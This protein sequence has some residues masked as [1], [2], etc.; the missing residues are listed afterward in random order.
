MLAFVRIASSLCI[1]Y[2]MKHEHYSAQHA[3][4]LVE[5]CRPIILPNTG[6]VTCLEECAAAACRCRLPLIYS[7]MTGSMARWRPSG[8]ILIL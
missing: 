7:L 3:R 1:A 2:L 6:F 4:S 5:G 8:S